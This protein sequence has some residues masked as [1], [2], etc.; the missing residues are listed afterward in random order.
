MAPSQAPHRFPQAAEMAGVLDAFDW[1][2]TAIGPPDQWPADLRA[3]VHLALDARIPM[4]LGWGPDFHLIYNDGYIPI[5]GDKHPAVWQ[6]GP[7][8]FRELWGT[9]AQSWMKCTGAAAPS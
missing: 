7:D 4:M 3:Q 1:T 8:A 6:T 5:L 2:S 9:S